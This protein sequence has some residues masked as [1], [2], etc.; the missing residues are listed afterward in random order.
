MDSCMIQLIIKNKWFLH[1]SKA[2]SQWAGAVKWSCQK[3]QLTCLC[4]TSSLSNRAASHITD[5]ASLTVIQQQHRYHPDTSVGAL[6]TTTGTADR[7]LCHYFVETSTAEAPPP[8]PKLIQ[9]CFK[10]FC[11]QAEMKEGQKVKSEGRHAWGD[12]L[13]WAMFLVHL[14]PIHSFLPHKKGNCPCFNYLHR[15][16]THV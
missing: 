13:I 12:T 4:S 7:T 10:I 11:K 16:H 6:E 1:K 2:D 8:K 5:T 14:H 3:S 9:T 15:P